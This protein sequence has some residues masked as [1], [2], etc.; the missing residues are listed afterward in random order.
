MYLFIPSCLFLFSFPNT[1]LN[2]DDIMY[3]SI[4]FKPYKNEFRK[5]QISSHHVNERASSKEG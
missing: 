4:L 1:K 3:I 5:L 2:K